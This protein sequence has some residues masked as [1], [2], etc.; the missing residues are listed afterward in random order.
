M[1]SNDYGNDIITVT[2]DDG[3]EYELEHLD[4]L[5]Y[6]NNTYM[7]FATAETV[8]SDE[9]E[10]ILFRVVDEGD[11]EVFESIDDDELMEKIYALFMERIESEDDDFDGE[12]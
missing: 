1:M 3:V 8:D 12:M 9:V 10:V 5:V 2:D 4:T 6:E 7:A 11:E